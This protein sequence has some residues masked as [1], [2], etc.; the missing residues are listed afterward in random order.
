MEENFGNKIATLKISQI[1]KIKMSQSIKNSV[2]N[3][4][5]KTNDA[6]KCRD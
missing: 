1:E 4:I 6:K 2:E 5:N 3:I